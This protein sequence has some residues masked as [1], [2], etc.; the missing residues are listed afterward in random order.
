MK[1]ALLTSKD[2]LDKYPDEQPFIEELN[3]QNVDFTWVVWDQKDINWNQFNKVIIRTTWDYQ[4]NYEHFLE[5]L[6]EIENSKATLENPLSIVKWNVDKSYLFELEKAGID[7]VP[8]EELTSIDESYFS[9]SRKDIVLKPTVSAS[10][11][12][13]FK[14]NDNNLKENIT[15][16]NDAFKRKTMIAQPFVPSIQSEGEY[17]L[18]YFYGKLSHAV[19]KKPKAGDFR[20][21]EQYDSSV[22]LIQPEELLLQAAQKL[23]DYKCSK[24]AYARIDMVRF[25]GKFCL[26]EL[27]IIEPSLYFKY[28][29]MASKN[30][31]KAILK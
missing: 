29:Q 1:I 5:V 20:S 2:E 8:T 28:D 22:T 21:Q 13:T 15:A 7:I 14:L 25:E 17:S 4:A 6:T 19:C 3:E 16:I 11:H 26:M 9:S 30:F 12:D 10:A 23:V 24:L 31:I 18:F 27:E